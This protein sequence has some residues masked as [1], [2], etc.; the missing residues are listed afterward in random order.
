MSRRAIDLGH[1]IVQSRHPCE[2]RDTAPGVDLVPALMAAAIAD[3]D[4]QRLSGVAWRATE[5]SARLRLTGVLASGGHADSDAPPLP[6]GGPRTCVRASSRWHAV[7]HASREAPGRGPVPAAPDSVGVATRE[8]RG[9]ASCPGRPRRTGT[10]TRPPDDL[11]SASRHVG[12]GDRA[13]GRGHDGHELHELGGDHLS[14]HGRPSHRRA[15]WISMCECH[16]C[17]S[18][19]R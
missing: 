17:R 8:P 4:G 5:E 14:R 19:P 16:S 18:R 1:D 2:A 10:T 7:E 3:L 6:G 13:H 9:A 15:G 11:S 12:D